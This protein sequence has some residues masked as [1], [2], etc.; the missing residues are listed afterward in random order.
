[1]KGILSNT[2]IFAA[3][4][5][6]GGLVTWRIL[7]RK[8]EE[9]IHEEVQDL[10]ARF[11]D[12]EE[13]CSEGEDEPASEN[14]EEEP[15]SYVGKKPD[16]SEYKEVLDKYRSEAEEETATAEEDGEP[17]VIDP[18]IFGEDDFETEFLTLYADGVLT[19]D[20][21][22]P[23]EDIKGHVGSDWQNHFGEYDQPECVCVRNI[24]LKTDYE[25][26]KDDRKYADLYSQNVPEEDTE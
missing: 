10:R 19:D 18:D 12:K 16:L 2:L 14:A 22:F 4:A 21:D 7:N 15:V 13:T 9:R 23:I 26:C 3:G 1:M 5:A 20:R 6:V 25:I 24:W 8:Y 11:S 17:Y